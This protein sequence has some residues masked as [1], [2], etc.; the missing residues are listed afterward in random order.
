MKHLPIDRGIVL[1]VMIF[2][3]KMVFCRRRQFFVLYQTYL[4][5]E[6][7]NMEILS[8]MLGPVTG[9]VVYKS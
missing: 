4:R 5:R 1:F 3:Q 9:G 2:L 6:D 7:T 8:A